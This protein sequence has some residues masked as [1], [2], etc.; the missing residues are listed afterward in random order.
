MTVSHTQGTS[1]TSIVGPVSEVN[2]NV[3]TLTTTTTTTTPWTD[4]VQWITIQTDTNHTCGTDYITTTTTTYTATQ[5]YDD[6]QTSISTETI[7]SA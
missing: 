7:T 5:T 2:G 4:V 3:Q 6:V 1:S